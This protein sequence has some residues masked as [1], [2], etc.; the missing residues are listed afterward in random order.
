MTSELETRTIA[1]NSAAD[2]KEINV[3]LLPKIG[4][5]AEQYLHCER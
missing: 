1:L 3:Y 5:N 4:F 2:K